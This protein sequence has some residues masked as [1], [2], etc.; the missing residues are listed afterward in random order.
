MLADANRLG[1]DRVPDRIFD[2]CIVGAGPAGITLARALADKGRSVALMEG[3]GLAYSE[4]SQG[5]YQGAS[6]GVPYPVA[7]SRLRYLGGSSNHWQGETRPLD[8]RDFDALPIHPLNDWPIARSHLDAYAAHADDILDL[9]PAVEPIDIFAGREHTLTAITRRASKPTRFGQKYRRELS[10][11]KLVWLC[12][13]ANL[14]DIALVESLTAVA[15]LSFRSHARPRPFKVRARRYALCCGGL[16]NA[17]ILLNAKRQIPPG[18]GNERDLVGRFFSEHIDLLLG[19]AVLASR[20]PDVAEYLPTDAAMHAGRCLSYIVKLV[21]AGRG[22]CRDDG[23][24]MFPERLRQAVRSGGDAYFNANVEV[25]VQQAAN[26]HSRVTLAETRDRLGLRRLSLD[27]RLSELDRH[28]IRTAALET[29]RALARHNVG[30]LQLAPYVDAGLDGIGRHC[31]GQSHHMCTTRMSDS[32]ATGVVNSDCRLH[33]VKNLYVGGS[34]VF[35]SCGASN[36]T[37]TIVMLA[38]R[39]ADHL[40]GQLGSGR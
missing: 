37:Y 11:S 30:R 34:S 39:L 23:C 17:R 16:E 3:G 14:V 29:G 28:T 36:P 26:R 27:W 8:H 20:L 32:P 9:T 40:D 19:R 24:G 7:S 21:P 35:A 38:L 18:L 22:N 1:G 2:V 6:V 4:A 12:L 33:G 15:H 31:V 25:G 13:N 5:L 10:R